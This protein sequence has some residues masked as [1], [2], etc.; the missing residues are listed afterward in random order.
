[1]RI[2]WKRFLLAGALFGLGSFPACT[3]EVVEGPPSGGVGG[4]SGAGGTGG[5]AGSTSDAAARDTGSDAPTTDAPAPDTPSG[6]APGGDA[7]PD[8]TPTADA[9]SDGT[10]SDGST[11]T[12]ASIDAADVSMADRSAQDNAA[13]DIAVTDVPGDAG[14]GCFAEDPPDAGTANDC[15]TL[16]YYGV[17]CRDDA[18]ADFPPVGATICT[19]LDTDLKGTAFL[20]LIA[21][22]KALPGADGGMDACSAAHEQGADDCSRAIFNRSMCPVPDGVVEGGLYGCSQIAASCGPD[23]GDGGIPVSVCQAWL[24]PFNA[25]AR[26]GFIDCYLDPTPVGATSCRDKFE[27]HC[28]FP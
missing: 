27:N 3:V 26:Q 24:G 13:P 25:A 9:G 1:M 18:G 23:S 14:N 22:L 16:P 5:T 11:A 21:C 15:A 12:D 10:V 19:S 7:L 20:E 2:G 28:V 8:G 6:D 17:L 4:T